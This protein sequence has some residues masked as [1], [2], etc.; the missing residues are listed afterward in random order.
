VFKS[1][2]IVCIGNICRSPVG[3]FLFQKYSDEYGLDLKIDSAGVGALVGEG[4]NRHSIHVSKE[5]GLDVS[6]HVAKQLTRELLYDYELVLV[7]DNEIRSIMQ[8]EYSY[9]IGK[10]KKMGEFNQLEIY[11]PY[12]KPKAAFEEMYEKTDACVRVWLERVWNV[13]FT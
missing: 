13:K 3:H 12:R 5:H 8:K 11:D 4:A 1:V 7:M 9:S 10:V 6:S 2:L